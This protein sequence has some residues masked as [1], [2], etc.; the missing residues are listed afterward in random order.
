M[1]CKIGGQRVF[2]GAPLMM[3]EKFL[4][5]SFSSDAKHEQH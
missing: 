3:K 5:S 1:V 2:V 4:T